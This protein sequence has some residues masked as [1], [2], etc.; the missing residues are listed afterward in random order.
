MDRLPLL[1]EEERQQVLEGWNETASGVSEG[2]VCPRVVRGAGGR[3][4]RR[5][6]RWCMRTRAELWGA[7][8]AGEPAGALSAR[9]GGGAGCAGGICVERSLEMVVGLLG[10]LKAGG[11]Y[12]PLDPAYPVERLIHAGGQRAGGVLTQGHLRELFTNLGAAAPVVD[13]TEVEPRW[14]TQSERN[15]KRPELG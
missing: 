4:R 5:R 3:R 1:G 10:V 11:A 6:W 8:R 7:Q 2:A 15:P 9:A 14:E 13:L 12:V